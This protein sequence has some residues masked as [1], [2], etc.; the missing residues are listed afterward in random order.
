LT[1]NPLPRYLSIALALSK[2]AAQGQISV[3]MEVRR[4]PGIG[5]G[6][7]LEWE[8]QGDAVVVGKVGPYTSEDIHWA[9]FAQ[10]VPAAKKVEE[11][12]QGVRRYLKKKHA[13]R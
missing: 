11:F 4:K 2:V 7:A 10:P 5:P 6:S 13:R 3:P 1:I 12:D 9:I 8:E